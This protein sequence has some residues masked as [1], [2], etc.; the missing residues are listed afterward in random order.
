MAVQIIINIDTKVKKD[1]VYVVKLGMQ[2]V[3][4]EEER[5]AEEILKALGVVPKDG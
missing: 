5:I 1:K 4:K 3:H 2:Q